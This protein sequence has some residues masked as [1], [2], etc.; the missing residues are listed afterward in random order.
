MLHFRP[1]FGHVA[2]WGCASPITEAPLLVLGRPPQGLV[3][4]R[5]GHFSFQLQ[6]KHFHPEGTTGSQGRLLCGRGWQ[7]WSAS[8][9]A[10]FSW[11]TRDYKEFPEISPLPRIFFFTWPKYRVFK[12]GGLWLD[13]LIRVLSVLLQRLPWK[14]CDTGTWFPLRVKCEILSLEKMLQY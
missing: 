3:D 11:L 12:L 7:S 10:S 1:R 2:M 4:R 5:E 6:E 9:D 13:V 14:Y 8:Q